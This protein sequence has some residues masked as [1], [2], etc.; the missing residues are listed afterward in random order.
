[1]GAALFFDIP[2]TTRKGIFLHGSSL[3]GAP[4]LK[5]KAVPIFLRW[6]LAGLLLC[7]SPAHQAWAATISPDLQETMDLAAPDAE[8]AVIVTL[9][10]RVNLKSFSSFPKETRRRHLIKALRDKA[11]V[12]QKPL[13]NLI[14]RSR[15]KHLR[16][17]WLINGIA[18]TANKS[19][20]A[21]L[22]DHPAVESIRA[23]FVISAPPQPANG[24]TLPEW[25]IEA[26]GAPEL[27]ALGF[28][29][30]GVVVANMDTG[31]D[32]NHPDLTGRWRGGS[33]S[34][35]DPNNEH[36]TL[37]HDHDGHGTQT[38]GLMVGGD[39]GG[40]AIGMA[41]G[42]QWLAVKIFNDQGEA[43]LSVIHL[44]Y[45]WLLDPD[46]DPL[47][48]DAPDIVNNSWGMID[49]QDSCVQ[50]FFPDIQTLKSAE[51]AVVFAAGNDGPGPATSSSPANNSGSFSVG[52]T[53]FFDTVADFSSRGPSAC[54]NEVFPTVTAP[55]VSVRTSDLTAPFGLPSPDPYA[56]PSGTSFAAPQVSGAM[57]LLRSASPAATIAQVENALKQSAWD[58]GMA[59]PDHD[60]GYGFI[61]VRQA[62]SLMPDVNLCAADFNDSGTVDLIDFILF[63]QNFGSTGCSGTTP[64]AADLNGDGVVNLLD[65]ILF[66]QEFGRS[67]CIP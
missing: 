12:T 10:D 19:F 8:V 55:G 49:T 21:R 20:I 15:A 53:D 42:A 22:A 40:S 29:G 4:T 41:P 31:V 33:N 38:M 32:L 66:R 56:N 37:P 27:W 17:L 59:G 9:R 28:T 11:A 36:P 60:Y 1:M 13:I 24:A 48:D 54:G 5:N 64:C 2:F 30:Q 39:A 14:K 43:A 46:G 23:D 51:I 6:L 63:R 65:F 61:N 44:G 45:Q 58:L 47:T 62:L 67:G 52:A 34:W 26:T 25:N 3:P 57:A 18:L 50:E 7:L 35:Y 16:P